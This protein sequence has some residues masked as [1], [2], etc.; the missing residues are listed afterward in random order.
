MSFKNLYKLLKFNHRYYSI[1]DLFFHA[2]STP[3][4]IIFNKRLN[5]MMFNIIEER[6]LLE[7]GDFTHDNFVDFEADTFINDVKNIAKEIEKQTTP[8]NIIFEDKHFLKIDYINNCNVNPK[9]FENISVGKIKYS[10]KYK[11]YSTPIHEG[12]FKGF[13]LVVETWENNINF[14]LKK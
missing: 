3:Q 5:E 2:P 14:T 12:F 11:S 6:N 9:I 13:N 1:N 10:R 4:E 7:F 8:E